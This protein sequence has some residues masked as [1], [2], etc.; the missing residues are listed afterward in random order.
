MKREKYR[1]KPHPASIAIRTWMLRVNLIGTDIVR[2]LGV[3]KS[4]VSHFIS[5]RQHTLPMRNYF[6]EKGCPDAILADLERLHRSKKKA[7]KG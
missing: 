1:K 6:I 3:D 2:E 4:Y 5:G 7:R